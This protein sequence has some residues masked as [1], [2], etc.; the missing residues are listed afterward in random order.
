MIEDPCEV[1]ALLLAMPPKDGR[2]SANPTEATKIFRD[3]RVKTAPPAGSGDLW[4][5]R[6]GRGPGQV[7]LWPNLPPQ[8]APAH[9]PPRLM[10]GSARFQA[11]SANHLRCLWPSGANGLPAFP[12]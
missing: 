3:P 10:R 2:S 7:E 11:G 5:L 12:L 1:V 9:R 8:Q 6:A 4:R